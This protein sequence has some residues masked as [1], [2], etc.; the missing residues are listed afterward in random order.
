MFPLELRDC[1]PP[2]DPFPIQDL[3]DARWQN[4][5]SLVNVRCLG[6]LKTKCEGYV[7]RKGRIYRAAEYEVSLL[8]FSLKIVLA[9]T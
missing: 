9:H 5:E 3:T 2:E 1:L 4:V 7:T 6:G 8:Y